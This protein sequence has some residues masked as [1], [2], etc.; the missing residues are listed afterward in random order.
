MKLGKIHTAFVL[1]FRIFS[2][3]ILSFEG[4]FLVGC[5]RGL[6]TWLTGAIPHLR[7]RRDADAGANAYA[8]VCEDRTAGVLHNILHRCVGPR[9]RVFSYEKRTCHTSEA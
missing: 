5:V 8:G 7:W 3:F 6:G 4:R 1:G 2:L 9:G